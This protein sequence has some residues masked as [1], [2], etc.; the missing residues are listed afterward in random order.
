MLERRGVDFLENPPPSKLSKPSKL[1]HHERPIVVDS[2]QFEQLRNSTRLCNRM[3]SFQTE[4][5]RYVYCKIKQ[6]QELK[7][8]ILK[9]F[10]FEMNGV[11]MHLKCYQSDGKW[12]M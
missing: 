7:D 6:R 2:V 10:I 4:F 11:E 12:R 1:D 8:S 9:E 3:G 5:V